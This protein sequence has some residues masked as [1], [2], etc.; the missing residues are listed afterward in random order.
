MRKKNNDLHLTQWDQER[1]LTGPYD[2]AETYDLKSYKDKYEKTNN[3][4]YILKRFNIERKHFI[5]HIPTDRQ[6]FVCISKFKK[7]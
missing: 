6:T 3:H 2:V 4:Y 5:Y 1:C 7:S